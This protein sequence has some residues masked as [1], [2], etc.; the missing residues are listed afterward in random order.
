VTPSL[1]AVGEVPAPTERE[2][3]TEPYLVLGP[4]WK[5]AVVGVPRGLTVPLRDAVVSVTADA[6]PV[7]TAGGRP[8]EVAAFAGPS[9]PRATST[10]KVTRAPTAAT[11]W[12]GFTVATRGRFFT[13]G[14]LKGGLPHVTGRRAPAHRDI[15]VDHHNP[16]KED[17]SGTV[18]GQRPGLGGRA[19]GAFATVRHS[20]LPAPTSSAPTS[21]RRLLGARWKEQPSRTRRPA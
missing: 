21:R 8:D 9:T 13:G 7:L 18:R 6:V 19:R 1:N 12:R 15:A 2:G 20:A 5:W 14:L 17:K 3:V 4:H 16:P 10:A 11:A